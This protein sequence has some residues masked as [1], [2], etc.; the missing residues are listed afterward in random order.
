MWARQGWGSGTVQGVS[1]L[2][3]SE[4]DRDRHLK[5]PPPAPPPRPARATGFR[6][7]YP[8][9]P[10]LGTQG[11]VSCGSYRMSDDCFQNERKPAVQH[12]R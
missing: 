10:V 3:A 2:T 4:D 5:R 12:R 9:Y 1:F 11:M 6:S 8:V 7:G